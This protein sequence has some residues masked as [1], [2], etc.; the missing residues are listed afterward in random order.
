MNKQGNIETIELSK[1]IKGRSLWVD[2]R[3]RLFLNKAAVISLI[4]LVIIATVSIFG[5]FFFNTTLVILIGGQFTSLQALKRDIILE[6]M[7][8][9]EIF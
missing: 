9:G 3:R 4:T 2:A 8:T 1:T 5:P 6:L 7:V